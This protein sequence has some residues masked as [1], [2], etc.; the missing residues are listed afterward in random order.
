MT[1]RMQGLL[2]SKQ[3]VRYCWHLGGVGLVWQGLWLHF[4]NML[5]PLVPH[6]R[7]LDVVPLPCAFSSAM[8]CRPCCI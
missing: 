1:V 8:Q 3:V 6:Q 7:Q 5:V 2:Y 4:E